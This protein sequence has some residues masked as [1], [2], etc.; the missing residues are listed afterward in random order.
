MKVQLK[1]KKLNKWIFSEDVHMEPNT[2]WV[3]PVEH[4]FPRHPSACRLV[5][6]LPW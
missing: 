3:L 2:R 5:L 6:V 1:K 4:T